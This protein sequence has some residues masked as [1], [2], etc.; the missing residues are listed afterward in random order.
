LKENSTSKNLKRMPGISSLSTNSTTLAES[1]NMLVAFSTQITSRPL[2]V[3]RL[4]R[5]M[6]AASSRSHSRTSL[7]PLQPEIQ[8]S[9]ALASS[10]RYLFKTVALIVRETT[11]TKSKRKSSLSAL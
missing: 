10:R 7:L 1:A 6:I 9:T 4:S 3:S 5:L 11:G 8:S 2:Q